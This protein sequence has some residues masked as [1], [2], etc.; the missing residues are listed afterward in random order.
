[1]EVPPALLR[2]GSARIVMPSRASPSGSRPGGEVVG[3]GAG[4]YGVHDGAL[5]LV[6]YIEVQGDRVGG[7]L[8]GVVGAAFGLLEVASGL[9]LGARRAAKCFSSESCTSLSRS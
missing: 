3:V 9:V 1:M 6:Q 7:V 5:G 4:E 2:A 8:L